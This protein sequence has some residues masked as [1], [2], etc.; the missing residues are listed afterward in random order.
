MRKINVDTVFSVVTIVLC[1]V[2]AVYAISQGSSAM[3]S[4][5]KNEAK[6]ETKKLFYIVSSEIFKGPDAPASL[7][8][9]DGDLFQ[10]IKP[11]NGRAFFVAT[12]TI[13]GKDGYFFVTAMVYTKDGN[14]IKGWGI[15]KNKDNKILVNPKGNLPAT[16]C[17]ILNKSLENTKK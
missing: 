3:S 8:Q 5:Q 10:A 15:I 11:E 16:L 12:T 13:L 6:D 1:G 2:L 14:G 7:G 9:S 17:L 4:S